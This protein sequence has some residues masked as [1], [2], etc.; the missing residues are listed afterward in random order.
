MASLL[1]RQRRVQEVPRQIKT[2]HRLLADLLGHHDQNLNMGPSIYHVLPQG[3]TDV[4]LSCNIFLGTGV[5]KI[6]QKVNQILNKLILDIKSEIDESEK[7][8]TDSKKLLD[9]AQNKLDSEIVQ[10]K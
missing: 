1:K 9:N 8:R 7:L 6:P 2:F 5:L 4:L 3:W 10:I